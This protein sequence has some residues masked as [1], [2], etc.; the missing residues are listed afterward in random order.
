MARGFFITF[1]GGEGSGKSTQTRRLAER[2]STDGREVVL[3]REPGGAPGAE[4]I[5]ALLVT[6]APDRW[7]PLAETL[8]F[9][10]ARDE[11]L[12]TTIRP[13]LA[14]GA[15]VISDRFADSTRAYQ[16]AAGGVDPAMIDALEDAVI[17]QMR[18]DLTFILDIDPAAGMARAAA[19]KDR[20]DRFEN[21][22][23]TFHKALRAAFLAIA[24]AEPGRC[25]VVA[26]NRTPDLIADEIQGIC[27]ARL[28]LAGNPHG[29]D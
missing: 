2:L 21:K 5:R 15:V 1:E 13:A 17:G 3:T 14:R 23:G 20:E 18:P 26:A 10:A 12:R 28:T 11:H 25:V 19:R 16:G 6:G 9:S 27:A 29:Q 24:A 8:L 4:D 22:A 7:T